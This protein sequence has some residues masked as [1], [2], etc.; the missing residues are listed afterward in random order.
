MTALTDWLDGLEFIGPAANYRTTRRLGGSSSTVP[1]RPRLI[2]IHTME[3]PEDVGRARSTAQWV[4]TSGG[5]AQVSCHFTADDAEAIRCVADEHVAFT[6][7]TPWNDMSL[8]IEQAG[9]A[10]QTADEWGDPYSLGQRGLVARIVAA[11]CQRWAIPPEYLTADDLVDWRNCTG[12]TTHH[13]I[14]LASQRKELTS[15]GYKPGNHT[16]PG[17]NYPMD[18]LLAEVRALLA[19]PITNRP[20]G[21]LMYR[22]GTVT[23]PNGTQA[24]ARFRV[25]LDADGKPRHLDWLEDDNRVGRCS[26]LTAI[27]L[28]IDHV[29]SCSVDRVP[30]GDAAFVAWA[31]RDWA[32]WDFLASS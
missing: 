27:G 29:F 2:V 22:L 6:Q 20:D 28:T 31:G 18:D 14:S 26:D 11:W 21:G 30:T 15:L 12:I 8:S 24:A 23:L 4:K 32:R 17:P 1:D 9:R 3:T 19:P 25:T 16:D 13:Q 7:L 5:S 10:A